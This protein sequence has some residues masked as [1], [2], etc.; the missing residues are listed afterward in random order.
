MPRPE[1]IFRIPALPVSRYD[2]LRHYKPQSLFIPLLVGLIRNK[3]NDQD[4]KKFL[5][6]AKIASAK[7]LESY[8]GLPSGTKSKLYG[9]NYR[10]GESFNKSFKELL[11]ETSKEYKEK[12]RLEDLRKKEAV[13]KKLIEFKEKSLYEIMQT[14]PADVYEFIAMRNIYVGTGGSLFRA[15]SYQVG[16]IR[17]KE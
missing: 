16:K 15:A 4:L 1:P 3:P 5:K 17:T 7:I 2:Y 13:R 14:K 10:D 11:I 8:D 9:R 12:I 6:D